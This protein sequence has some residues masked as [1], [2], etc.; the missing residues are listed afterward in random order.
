MEDAS[1]VDLD[2]FWRGWFFSTDHVD[3]A[4]GNVKLYDLDTRDPEVEKPKRKSK[5]EEKLP[6]WRQELA[7]D[8]P[9][10]VERFPELQDFYNAY[11]ELDVTDEDRREFEKYLEGLDSWERELLQTTERFY[12]VDFENQGGLFTPILLKVT[13]ADGGV[14][15]L[16][17]PAEI[18]SK[19]PDRVSKLLITDREIV[20]LEVDPRRET[21][22]ADVDDNDWPKRPLERSFQ[23]QKQKKPKNPMQKA[24]DAELPESEGSDSADSDG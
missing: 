1:A 2:W 22:D 11:D 6:T 4:I 19:S 5:R 16:D 20:S 17:L 14:E 13:Y 21:A 23:L 24:R 10:R 18:W 7:P 8:E 9:K 15:R 12:V 3:V